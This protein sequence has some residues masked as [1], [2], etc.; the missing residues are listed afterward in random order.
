MYADNDPLVLTHARTLLAGTPGTTTYLDADLRDPGKI[1]HDATDSL[2]FSQPVAVMLVAVLH[3]I[4]DAAAPAD[5]ISTPMAAVPPGSCLVISHP[6]A[7]LEGKAVEYNQSVAT[8]RTRRTRRTR[9]QVTSFFDGLE[10]LP[11]RVVQTP[12]W[13][14]EAPP[15]E[16]PVPM[17][18]R[19]ARKS[20]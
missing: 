19:V 18:A 1:L 20:H 17:R 5:I 9:E 4:A 8:G 2:D 16:L 6:A 12:L 3:H 13:R 7:D 11:P 15:P 14:S 10:L